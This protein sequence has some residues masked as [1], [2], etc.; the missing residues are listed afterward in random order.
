VVNAGDLPDRDKGGEEKKKQGQVANDRV[1]VAF[2]PLRVD[3]IGEGILGRL[4]FELEFQF[5]TELSDSALL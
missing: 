5:F 4:G 2:K 1:M 3:Q